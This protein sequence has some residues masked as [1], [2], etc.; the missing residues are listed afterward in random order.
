MS[1]S[2]FP[3][4]MTSN[5]DHENCWDDE[6][7]KPSPMSRKEWHIHPV[8]WSDNV[9]VRMATGEKLL[10]EH[11][12]PVL[13]SVT[14]QDCKTTGPNFTLQRGKHWLSFF[15]PSSRN[16]LFNQ[17][18]DTWMHKQS[19]LCPGSFFPPCYT[20]H[21]ALTSD[22]WSIQFM[23]S[24]KWSSNIDMLP[25]TAPCKCTVLCPNGQ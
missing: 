5:V 11:P 17:G 22:S 20:L 6:W 13:C 2:N 4:F 14:F 8:S 15:F 10:W 23:T 12:F 9:P 3:M 7:T 19:N 21:L 18:P 16:S 24:S 25:G 1:L